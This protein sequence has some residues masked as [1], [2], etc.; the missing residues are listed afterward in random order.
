MLL[1][2]SLLFC[3]AFFSAWWVAEGALTVAFSSPNDD[4]MV[5]FFYLAEFFYTMSFVLLL[6][7]A[8]SDALKPGS[9]VG[10][11]RAGSEEYMTAGGQ[12]PAHY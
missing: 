6:L 8:R 9:E 2:S 12:A 10:Q 1:L 4:V 11:K 3:L 7:I 5:A